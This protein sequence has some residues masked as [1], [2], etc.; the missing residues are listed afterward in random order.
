[1]VGGLRDR[2]R[3]WRIAG[4]GGKKEK[5]VDDLKSAFCFWPVGDQAY[6][7]ADF[8]F[9]KLRFV[10]KGSVVHWIGFYKRD[11]GSSKAIGLI[12]HGYFSDKKGT[13]NSYIY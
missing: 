9:S 5:K 11:Y 8:F 2:C 4:G 6:R 12:L 3:A 10:R 13:I 1:M 7:N